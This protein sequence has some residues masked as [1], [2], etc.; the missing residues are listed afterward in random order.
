MVSYRYLSDH[1]TETLWWNYS[2][3]VRTMPAGKVGALSEIM[4][5]QVVN[6]AK[7]LRSDIIKSDAFCDLT[8]SKC[9]ALIAKS[10]KIM[11]QH[12]FVVLSESL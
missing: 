11:S 2:R 6:F 3:K 12:F 10:Q 8:T 9:I 7:N 1:K 5:S 4:R